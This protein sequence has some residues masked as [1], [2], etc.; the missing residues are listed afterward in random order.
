MLFI[1]TL[2]T[3]H[4]FFPHAGLNKPPILARL[5]RSLQRRNAKIENRLDDF[6][7]FPNNECVLTHNQVIS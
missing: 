4:Y 6:H 2:W 5:T 1:F 7:R 3:S